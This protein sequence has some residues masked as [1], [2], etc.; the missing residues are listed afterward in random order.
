MKNAAG[1]AWLKKHFWT[2]RLAMRCVWIVWKYPICAVICCIDSCWKWAFESLKMMFHHLVEKFR[3]TLYALSLPYII[4]TKVT[5]SMP[6]TWF[7]IT[8]AISFVNEFN[9]NEA[10]FEYPIS[11]RPHFINSPQ[12][13]RRKLRVRSGW[14]RPWFTTLELWLRRDQS[15]PS[16]S[17]MLHTTRNQLLTWSNS[18][19]NQQTIVE[20]QIGR[21]KIDLFLTPSLDHSWHFQFDSVI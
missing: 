21:K 20:V 18:T 16:W 4:N 5:L 9:V 2:P 13:S 3:L 8:S 14:P 17:C 6:K 1:L 12:L 15:W 10:V 11:W 7:S 19:R